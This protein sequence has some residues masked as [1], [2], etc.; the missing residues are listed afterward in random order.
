M[1][2]HTRQNDE[3]TFEFKFQICGDLK[4]RVQRAQAEHTSRGMGYLSYPR[5]LKKVIYQ[6]LEMEKKIPSAFKSH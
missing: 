5:A 3:C 1:A 4:E 6:L 2:N